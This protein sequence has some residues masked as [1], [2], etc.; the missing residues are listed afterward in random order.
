MKHLLIGEE[1]TY[2]EAFFFLV[3]GH[4]YLRSAA[5]CVRFYV[6]VRLVT[7]LTRWII[8][9]VSNVLT[10]LPE[11]RPN[12]EMIKNKKLPFY[13]VV[14]KEKFLKN[15]MNVCEI[16]PRDGEKYLMFFFFSKIIRILLLFFVDCS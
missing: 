12:L 4:L 1:Y 8:I 2:A 15:E 9:V 5:K 6:R 13:D 10:L 11:A 7:A 14:I 16:T 3:R